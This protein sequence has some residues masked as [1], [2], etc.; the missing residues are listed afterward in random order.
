MQGAQGYYN[1]KYFSLFF[2]GLSPVERA[3][4]YARYSASE[5][6]VA[7]LQLMLDL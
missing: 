3:G 4:Y 5:D 7:G 2:M 6:W 1:D